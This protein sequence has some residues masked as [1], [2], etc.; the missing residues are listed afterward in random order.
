MLAHA[1]AL[2]FV[3]DHPRGVEAAGD[4]TC[5]VAGGALAAGFLFQAVGGIMASLP[6]AQ[7][8]ITA[9]QFLPGVPTWWVP[10]SPGGAAAWGVILGVGIVTMLAGRELRRREGAYR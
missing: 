10:E 6:A 2:A 5:R 1:H 3:I 8:A 9:A 4:V 7:G